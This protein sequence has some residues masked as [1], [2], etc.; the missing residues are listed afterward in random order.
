MFAIVHC[1]EIIGL[2]DTPRFVKLRNGV[3][4]ECDKAEAGYVAFAGTAYDLKG[5]TFVKPVDGSEFAFKESIKLEGA[6]TDVAD[7]QDAIC[8]LSEDIEERL[9]EIEDAL[10]EIT[11]EEQ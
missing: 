7:S 4:V 8:I 3:Y 6:C 11:K 10:C 1:G 2:C 9:A 5:D